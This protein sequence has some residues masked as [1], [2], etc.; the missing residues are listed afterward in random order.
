MGV[1]SLSCPERSETL[2]IGTQQ[3]GMKVGLGDVS[4]NHGLPVDGS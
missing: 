2:T 3:P 4:V 1:A